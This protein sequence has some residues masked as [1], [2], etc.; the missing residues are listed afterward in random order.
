MHP[1]RFTKTTGA[2]F[3]AALLATVG[4]ACNDPT[5]VNSCNDRPEC[6]LD[7]SSDSGGKRETPLPPDSTGLPDTGPTRSPLCGTAGCVPDNPS[8]C[9]SVALVDHA[10][11][12]R[13]AADDAATSSDAVATADGSTDAGTVSDAAD[14]ED[15][16]ACQADGSH[17]AADPD[18]SSDAA[19]P[20]VSSDAAEPDVAEDAVAEPEFDA[21]IDAME[22]PADASIADS[23]SRPDAPSDG[24]MSEEPKIVQG[25][26]IKP[27]ATGVVTEC[28]PVGPGA[29]GSTCNDSRECGAQLACVEV[30]QKSACRRIT[31][32]LPPDCLK[33]TY[34][35]EAPLRANGTT[36]SD[37]KVPACLPTDNCTLLGPQ[38]QCPSGKVC[39]IVGSDGD[40]TCRVP[41]SSKVGEAC[42]E[43]NT[44]AEGLL[45]S[46][47]SNQCA[48]ICHVGD[49]DSGVKCA[50]GTCQGGNRSLPEGFGICVGQT[51]GG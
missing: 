40:T 35:Q 31:C 26:Y 24:G 47:F 3:V 22:P 23:G 7:G 28:A 48:K 46:K 13:R 25:C 20:D 38:E 19:D 36:R 30:D 10:F 50:T 11:L 29:E 17:D 16:D 33:G 37:L 45:C 27:A 32:F 21:T 15:S 34:Y 9:G 14:D 41:G 5:V 44:C 6:F 1:I 2:H 4:V 8:A 42:D 51:D 49:D 18:V 43:T 12:R 39:A